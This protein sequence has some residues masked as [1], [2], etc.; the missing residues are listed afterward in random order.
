MDV[1][2]GS[3]NIPYQLKLLRR[4]FLLWAA[5]RLLLYGLAAGS[6]VSGAMGTVGAVLLALAVATLCALDA[7]FMRETIF[8][9]NLGTPTWAPAAAGMAVSL[10]G[11]AAELLIVSVVAS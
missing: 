4:A 2:A 7:R 11:F 1:A 9:A 3:V 8:Q 10:A 5:L 6:G